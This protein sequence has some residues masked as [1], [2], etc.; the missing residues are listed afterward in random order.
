MKTIRS[1]TLSHLALL[2]FLAG[3]C[4]NAPRPPVSPP[5]SVAAAPGA[6]A[7]LR[8]AVYGDTRDGHE[9]H[10]Q[11]VEHVLSFHPAFVLQ[12][13]DLVHN[14]GNAEEWKTFDGITSAMRQQVPYYP[15]R[16]NH[17]VASE[18]Y[19]EQRVTQPILSGN[20]LY[21]SF[22]KGTLHFVSIDTEQPL[23][24]ESEE[25]RW[26]EDDLAQAQS[27]GRFII[28]FFHKAMFSIGRH[29]AQADVVAL[30]SILHPLFKRYGVRLAFEGHDHLYYHTIRDDIT[31]VVTGGGGAPL[32]DKEHPELGLPQDVFKKAYH[33]CIVD[34][35]ADRVE[36]SA[37]RSDLAEIDR[38][39]VAM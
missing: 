20:K 28:P 26:L 15:A 37:Y 10:R 13:G 23:G 25:G 35:Y 39:E 32:Y 36:V 6:D 19:Y 9:V 29:A 24:P 7:S 2:I 11:I 4:T 27:A 18:G 38:F 21:Y 12:T 34:V 5:P 1:L 17:D 30:K 3:A 8:F 33:F 16:G 14:G 22:E 31:Y